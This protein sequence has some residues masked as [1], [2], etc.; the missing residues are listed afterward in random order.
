MENPARC[1][2]AQVLQFCNR[3]VAKSTYNV[4]NLTNF[5]M[6]RPPMAEYQ[7]DSQIRTSM[8][9]LSLAKAVESTSFPKRK[10]KT[11][12]LNPEMLSTAASQKLTHLSTLPGSCAI[13]LRAEAKTHVSLSPPQSEVQELVQNKFKRLRLLRCGDAT[14]L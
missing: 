5:K 10:T 14:V 8:L 2:T 6:K 13:V 1:K 12:E 3:V 9:S 7:L 4:N 11:A